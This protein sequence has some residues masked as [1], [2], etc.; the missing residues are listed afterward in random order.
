MISD[1]RRDGTDVKRELCLKLMRVLDFTKLCEYVSGKMSEPHLWDSSI[2]V[3]ALNIL[4][5]KSLSVDKVIRIGANKFFVIDKEEDLSPSLTTIQGYFYTIK[6]LQAGI[7]LN[8]NYGTS[9]F[10]RSQTVDHFLNDTKTFHNDNSRYAALNALRVE[11]Q[12][13][14]GKTPKDRMRDWDD[15]PGREKTISGTS[16]STPLKKLTFTKQTPEGTK[17][18]KKVLDYLKECKLYL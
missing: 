7:L 10:Y 5:S 16:K 9:A 12:Y 6:P 15:I 18:E 17:L 1:G 14:R 13:R 8:V 11:I 4:I 2:E 3:K